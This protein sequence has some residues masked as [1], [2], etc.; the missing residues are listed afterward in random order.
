MK[1]PSEKNI[2]KQQNFAPK[3]KY[4]AKNMNSL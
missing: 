1:K 2:Q 4:F 3:L